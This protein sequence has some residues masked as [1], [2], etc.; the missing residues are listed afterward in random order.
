M[1]AEIALIEVIVLMIVR[2]VMDWRGSHE[3]D[4]QS[5]Y[6][7][8]LDRHPVNWR[9]PNQMSRTRGRTS[10]NATA[11]APHYPTTLSCFPDF[12]MC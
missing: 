1:V 7:D 8:H 11:Q 12:P 2:W 3:V 4:H 5:K 10:A 6:L 9:S